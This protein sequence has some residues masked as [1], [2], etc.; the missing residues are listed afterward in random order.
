LEQL[1]LLPY[2]AER[3]KQLLQSLD[4]LEQEIAALNQRVEAEVGQ[5]AAARKL[6][7]HPGVG[8]V[9]ALAMVLTLGPAER[10][11]SGKQVGSYFGLIPS[12]HSSGG[13]QKLGRI[14]KQG[15]SFLRFLL[16]E[17]GQS[18]VRQDAELGRFYRRLAARK[19]RALAK[20]AVARKLATRLY[21]MLREDW[22]YAQ[23]CRAMVSAS[24]G[25]SVVE[26]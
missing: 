22:T 19:H 4:R 18:A 23:L 12:E 9:T 26:R 24:P 17:A 1:E 7:T 3:R 25:H 2:A 5:R 16:V 8:P 11:A 10:F 21:L 6:Q 14:S 15:S 20:V 13:R